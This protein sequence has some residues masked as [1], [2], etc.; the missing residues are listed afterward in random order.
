MKINPHVAQ[1]EFLKDSLRKGVPDCDSLKL[2]EAAVLDEEVGR[3]VLVVVAVGGEGRNVTGVDS[4]GLE[5]VP[6]IMVAKFLA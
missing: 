6:C 4:G 2:D 1:M 5:F 3:L